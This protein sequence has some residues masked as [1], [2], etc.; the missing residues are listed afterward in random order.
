MEN[1]QK[2]RADIDG[3]RAIAVI[4]VVLFH[5]HVAGFSGGFVGVDVFF[6]L[7]GYLITRHLADEV[8]EKGRISLS[9]FY[10]KRIRRLLPSILVVVS[11]I[12]LLW[13]IF[14]LGVKEDTR[15]LIKSVTSSLFGF[16]N[17]FF[18]NRTGG[19]FDSSS[20]EMP[21][22]HFW[23][24]GVEEQFYAVWPLMMVLILKCS[25]PKKIKSNFSKALFLVVVISFLVSCY[26]VQIGKSQIAFYWMPLRAWELGLGG[27]LALVKPESISFIRADRFLHQSIVFT[28]GL[29]LVL[30]PM[31]FF[32]E[33][34]AFPGIAA[35][36]PV[37]G[38]ALLVI[39]GTLYPGSNFTRIYT[40]KFMVGIGLLSYGIYLWHWPLLAML[41]VWNL[42][43]VPPLEQRLS[44][45]ALSILLSKITLQYV[46]APIRFLKKPGAKWTI[47]FGILASSVLVAIAHEVIK[48]ERSIYG[49]EMS[50]YNQIVQERGD[51]KKCLNDLKR[52]D[53]LDCTLFGAQ[54]KHNSE[55]EIFVWGDSHAQSYFPIFEELTRSNI[56]LSTTLI[57][58][59]S[60]LPLM[61]IGSP[62]SDEVSERVLSFIRARKVKNKLVVMAGRWSKYLGVETISQRDRGGY[63]DDKKT[64][65][66]SLELF[67]KGLR[68]SISELKKAG[69]TRILI[70]KQF[71]EFRFPPLRCV[72]RNPN[73]CLVTMEDF[74]SY[75]AGA[76][77]VIDG[78]AGDNGF[79]RVV[80]PTTHYCTDSICNQF[81][82]INQE[83][84]PITRDQNHPTVIAAE[85][86]GKSIALDLSWLVKF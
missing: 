65:D 39:F 23:S 11:S 57:S 35:L 58:H 47:F 2:Y 85:S 17:I 8:S 6:V 50:R 70:I 3:L 68:H 69:V 27:L 20:D 29:A 67:E 33:A 13:T 78:V 74:T 59:T 5:A 18:F 24:L 48:L 62:E 41:K 43:D 52:V 66:G 79:I 21:L 72:Q 10:A 26:L 36:P 81:K 19:Y 84:V 51:F 25:D 15:I 31:F 63:L 61:N 28:L 75:T 4:A 12:L 73:G 1:S 45:I 86:L 16:A 82:A 53:S 38:T 40:N 32:D 64:K 83:V 46:E 76:S 60:M 7:S 37:V 55:T 9:V 49:A 30:F 14:L 77:R 80:D 71:P 42:G 54:K 34:T 44:A 56:H 22:L